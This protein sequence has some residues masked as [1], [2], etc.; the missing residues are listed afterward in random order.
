MEDVSETGVASQAGIQTIAGD[1]FGSLLASALQSS[2]DC[3]KLIEVDGTI[4]FM[5]TNGQCAMEI[6]DFD[7]FRGKVWADIW[8]VASQE[9]VRTSV[10]RAV[11]GK[12]DRF[13]AWCPTGGGRLRYWDVRVAPV[14]AADGTVSRI[15]ATSRDVTERALGANYTN[16]PTAHK[17]DA[18]LESHEQSSSGSPMKIPPKHDREAARLASLK[19]YDVLDTEADDAFDG[20]TALAARLCGTSIALVSL[21]DSDRQWFKSRQGLDVAETPRDQALCA[22]AI[23]DEHILIVPDTLEDLRFADNPLC[24]GE[25]FVRFYAG[26]PL[27]GAHG[28]PLGTL[29]VIDQK[30]KPEG[31]PVQAQRDLRMLADQVVKLLEL[32]RALKRQE[33]S[34]QESVHRTR[35]V[36][37]VASAIAN[38]TICE[39][40]SLED[41][42][43]TLSAR[44]KALGNAQSFL[45]EASNRGAPLED[46]VKRQLSGFVPDQDP[47]IEVKGPQARISGD[48]A[49]GIGLALHELVT[50]ALKH[51][52][53]SL[54][55]GTV[56]LSWQPAEDGTL[57][58]EWRESGGP[59]PLAKKVGKGFG[60]LVLGPLAAEKIGGVAELKLEPTG[61]YWRAEIGPG[62]VR[63]LTRH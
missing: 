49:Q 25:P 51:G 32:K 43:H 62:H 13:E 9:R 1:G 7:L 20:I 15:I 16:G 57:L 46:L 63:A 58:L 38:R 22:H 34:L 27:I 12:Q 42:R 11:A 8:P 53:L 23:L 19:S 5:N 26:A 56:T 31:L 14:L 37:A 45:L 52:A 2:P 4:S 48:A 18:K 17:P 44:L 28:L 40:E 54:E 33:T 60:S 10:A 50:N 47:R 61:A 3:V 30:P 39:A 29:C 6:S 55:S 41:A 36:A 35:N 21:V 59:A 24:V